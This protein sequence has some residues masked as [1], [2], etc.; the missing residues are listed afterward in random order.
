MKKSKQITSYLNKLLIINYEAEKIF[1]QALEEVKN[2]ILKNFFRVSGYE[3]NQIIKQLDSNIRQ[4][5]G[6]P[7]Y[8]EVSHDLNS[9]LSSNLSKLISNKDEQLLFTEIGRM[10]LLD[11]QKY[12]KVLNDFDFPEA[13]EQLLVS[14]KD[15]IV[16]SLYSIE[17]HKDLFAKKIVSFD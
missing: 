13:I 8:P 14:Q 12:Q 7:T 11:I 2:S 1:L 9:E 10:K 16:K 17:V 4:K 3:R 5:G 6:T 15:T